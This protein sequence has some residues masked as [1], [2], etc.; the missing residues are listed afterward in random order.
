MLDLGWRFFG[1]RQSIRWF[2]LVSKP[3]GRFFEGIQ[4]DFLISRVD[5]SLFSLIESITGWRRPRDAT[6]DEG[7]TVVDWTPHPLFSLC[8]VVMS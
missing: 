3:I 1:V 6:V 5:R 2:Q 4:N 7:E 8:F